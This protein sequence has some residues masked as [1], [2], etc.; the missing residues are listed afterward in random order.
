MRVCKYILYICNIHIHA[1]ISTY[2]IN[3]IDKKRKCQEPHHIPMFD[4]K[5]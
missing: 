1:Y 2:R 4:E 5:R 3:D